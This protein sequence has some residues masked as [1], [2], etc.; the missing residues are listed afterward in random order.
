[1]SSRGGMS[2]LAVWDFFYR[3]L[4]PAM[5]TLPCDL[6]TLQGPHLLISS[7]W[8]LGFKHISLRGCDT[9]IQAVTIDKLLVSRR[10]KRERL[11]ATNIR[12]DRRDVATDPMDIKVTE[13]IIF[14]NR[15]PQ[16]HMCSLVNSTKH[17]M[18]IYTNS[19]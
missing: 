3:T 12:N 9:S 2:K 7:L 4:I 17:L 1:M 6:I 10:K 18:A 8:E 14:P 11:Q 16:V 5:R 13:L 15:K 19:L